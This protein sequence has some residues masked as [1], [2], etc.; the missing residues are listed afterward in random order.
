MKKIIFYTLSLLAFVF[1]F[2]STVSADVIP[3][4]SHS[5]NRC[6]KIVNLNEFPDIVL[7]GYYTGPM[8]QNYETYQIKNNECWTKGYKF[9]SLKIY[10]NTKDKS[11]I[12][13][14]NNLLLDDI[15]TYGGYVD[16]SNPLVKEN[17]EY[18]IAGFSDGKLI[19][20][21]SKQISEYN[22]GTPMKVETFANPLK[23]NEPNNQ[24]NQ[25][26]TPTPNPPSQI[27]PI[28]NEQPNIPPTPSPTPVKI[29]FWQTIICFFRNLFGRGCQ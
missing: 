7:I 26:I 24:N 19:L 23:N 29:G 8:V 3:P 11:N 17:I 14:P 27:T 15:E 2:S 20:Y 13:D 10:W 4:N 6:V 18:S 28:P 1:L 9:N 12:I 16:R 25:Q 22:D 5:F 21:K